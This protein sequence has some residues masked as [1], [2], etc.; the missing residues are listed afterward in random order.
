M[1]LKW[2]VLTESQFSITYCIDA[3]VEI[4]SAYHSQHGSAELL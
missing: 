4:I 1:D 2:Q 3:T